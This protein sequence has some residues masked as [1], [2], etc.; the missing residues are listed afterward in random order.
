MVQTDVSPPWFVIFGSNLR[1][2]HWSYKRYLER[3]LRDAYDF[4]GTPV[5]FSF[6][7]EKQLKANREKSA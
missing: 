4:T 5:M 7:D 6:R 3:S 1:L 2:L